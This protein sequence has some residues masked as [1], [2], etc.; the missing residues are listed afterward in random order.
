MTTTGRARAGRT[1]VTGEC[2][3]CGDSQAFADLDLAKD[4]VHH[5]CGTTRIGGMWTVTKASRR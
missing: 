5:V 2:V 4:A 3:V 1:L